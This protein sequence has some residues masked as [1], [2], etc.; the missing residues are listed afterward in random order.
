MSLYFDAVSILT[1]SSTVGGS[2][3]SR[4]YSA[5]NLRTSPAQVYALITEASKWDRVLTE[6]I[7]HADLLPQERKVRL[8]KKTAFVA[9]VNVLLLTNQIIK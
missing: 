4:I 7:E 5:Q 3:K 1:T 9:L 2:F 8:G 6:V